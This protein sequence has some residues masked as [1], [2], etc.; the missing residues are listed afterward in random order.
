MTPIGQGSTTQSGFKVGNSLLCAVEREDIGFVDF[1]VMGE[2]IF[3]MLEAI[4]SHDIVLIKQIKLQNIGCILA[5]S[6]LSQEL[7]SN[8]T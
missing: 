2:M 3:S 1:H 7:P 8:C 5:L 4:E 6:D